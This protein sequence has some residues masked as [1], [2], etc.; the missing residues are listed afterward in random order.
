MN[1]SRSKIDR[2]QTLNIRQRYLLL[3]SKNISTFKIK[4]I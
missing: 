2:L 4:I 1:L 3:G